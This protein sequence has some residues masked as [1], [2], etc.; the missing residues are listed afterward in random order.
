MLDPNTVPNMFS[1]LFIVGVHD[2]FVGAW[3]TEYVQQ[4][5]LLVG[6]KYTKDRTKYTRRMQQHRTGK[7]VYLLSHH[8]VIVFETSSYVL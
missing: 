7:L 3:D 5:G 1:L 4:C 6:R 2:E 8:A